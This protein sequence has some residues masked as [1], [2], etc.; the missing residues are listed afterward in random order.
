MMKRQRR[1]LFAALAVVVSIAMIAGCTTKAPQTTTAPTAAPVAT[2][3]ISN[4][5]NLVWY[6]PGNGDEPDKDAVLNAVNA[7]LKP[8][9]NASL[10]LR[11]IAWGSYDTTVNPLLSAG[12]SSVDIVFTAS[13]AANYV[14]NSSSGYFLDLTDLLGK[15]GQD[16]VK[17]C[18]TD[19]L[20]GCKINGKQYAIPCNK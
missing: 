19:F 18:G 11:T 2:P 6:I 7:Y 8:K 5:V 3:D 15:Y 4:A 17:A 1:I 13:W 10:D 16:I 14:Q 9:I 20:G 12:D